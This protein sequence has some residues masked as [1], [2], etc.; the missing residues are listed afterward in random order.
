[1]TI[2]RPPTKYTMN[3]NLIKLAAEF[4][5]YFTSSNNVD[6]PARVTV[7]RDEWRQLY[8][9]IE[10]TLNSSPQ[11]DTKVWRCPECG[12]NRLKEPCK[13]HNGCKLNIVAQNKE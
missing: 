13:S 3:A 8:A 5:R 10:Q 2:D 4:N 11:P 7:S 1:M 12:A 6:V 9:A